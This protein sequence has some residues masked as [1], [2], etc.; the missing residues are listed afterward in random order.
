MNN[1]N[2]NLNK[3][4]LSSK[5]GYNFLNFEIPIEA[6][7]VLSDLTPYFDKF[8][9]DNKN[10]LG[11]YISVICQVREVGNIYYTIGERFPIN[12]D[13]PKDL[14]DYMDYIQNK[15]YIL[16]YNQYNPSLALSVIFNYTSI[17]FDNYS[18]VSNK[19]RITKKAKIEVGQKKSV[20][21][22]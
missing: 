12:I 19:F 21:F 3:K 15:W 10:N 1:K 14:T 6:N 11:E 5:A 18:F 8:I 20:N 2:I 9:K 7:T 13:N 17:T 4:F 16:N 22:R